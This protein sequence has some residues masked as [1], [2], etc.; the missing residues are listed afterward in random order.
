MKPLTAQDPETQSPDIV[1][2]NIEQLQTLFPEA[3]SPKAGWTS[4]F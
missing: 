4:M 2:E 3:C 1:A